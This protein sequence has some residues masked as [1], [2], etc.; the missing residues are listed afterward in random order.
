MRLNHA[1]VPTELH[2]YAG[3]PHGFEGFAMG[4]DVSRRC[5]R[6]TEEWLVRALAGRLSGRGLESSPA[7]T[8]R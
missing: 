2:V 1:G 8:S 5:L 7:L 3:A 4:A 6:E